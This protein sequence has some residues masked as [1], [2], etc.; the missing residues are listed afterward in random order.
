MKKIYTLFLVIGCGISL[1]AQDIHF[2]QT[3]NAPLWMNPALTGFTPGVA[4]V[5]INYRNQ[6]FSGPN[7]GFFKSPYMTTALMADMPFKVKNDAIGVGLMLANDQ[8]GANTFSGIVVNASVAYIK[9]LGKRQNH[10][11]SAGLQIGYTHESVKSENFQYASQFDANNQFNSTLQ[12]ESLAKNSAG[13]LN[14]N[15]GL[16]WY[17]KFADKLGAYAGASFFNVTSP[18]YDV[19]PGQKNRLYWRWN[20]HAGLD[21]ILAE[22]YHLLPSGLFTRQGVN[23]QLNTGLGL[24]YDIN[25]KANL[26]IGLYNRISNLSSGVTADGVIP[27]FAFS[28]S[29]FKLGLSYDA[30]LS[31][32]KNAG[33]GVGALEI[34]L[35]YTIQRKEYNFRN[36]LMCP[37]F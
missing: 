21:I 17:G 14:L 33:T 28:I 34:H 5:G 36:A 30:T 22:K 25:P 19:L 9:T 7:N 10:R 26:T 4:R 3:F 29:G 32:L 2:S 31:G 20:V 6:W 8:Q 24:G 13:Y 12:G 15:A 1:T 37:R 27:Y 16:L 18:K 23:D 11:L 35:S